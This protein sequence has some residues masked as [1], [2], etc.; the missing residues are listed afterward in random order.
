[1]EAMRPTARKGL[2]ALPFMDRTPSQNSP[3]LTAGYHRRYKVTKTGAVR[4]CP[5]A[6]SYNS[7]L[8]FLIERLLRAERQTNQERC[9]L[10]IQ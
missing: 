6:D 3:A 7:S 10:C 8:Q 4:T 5:V 1:M 9:L 2:R